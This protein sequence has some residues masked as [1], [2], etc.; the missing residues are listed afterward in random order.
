[1]VT[2]IKE[3]KTGTLFHAFRFFYS[4]VETHNRNRLNLL[5]RHKSDDIVNL[6]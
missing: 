1:M 3:Y 2:I 4:F 5:K 6:S